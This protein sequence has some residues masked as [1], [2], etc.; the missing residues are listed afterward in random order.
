MCPSLPRRHCVLPPLTLVGRCVLLSLPAA[1]LCLGTAAAAQ[2]PIALQLLTGAAVER[3]Q[4]AA[5]AAAA[6]L[7]WVV[8]AAAAVVGWRRALRL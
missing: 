1:R 6:A 4:W 8:A 5:A 7:L 3:C 2:A